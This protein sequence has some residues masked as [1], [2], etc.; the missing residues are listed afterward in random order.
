MQKINTA[1][2]VLLLLAVAYLLTDKFT[3][4]SSKAAQSET[5]V[6]SSTSDS[7]E[8]ETLPGTGQIAF[9]NLD[10]LNA[11][12]TFLSDKLDLMQSEQLRQQ[13]NFERQARKVEERYLALQ[14]EAYKMTQDQLASAQTEMEQ[15]Q[16]QLQASQDRIS[17]ELIA[18]ESS[19][20]SELDERI[21]KELDR[22][23]SK[24]GFDYILAKASGSGVL[25]A[26]EQYDITQE[27][28]DGLNA[29]YEAEQRDE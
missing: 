4:A 13:K 9:V 20:Q 10:T 25:L 19:I 15:A 14:D 3:T 27:V 17:R 16:G 1:L 26:Q 5:T 22:V 24:Y 8:K 29:V 21:N 28:L 7:T 18:L 12:F 6:I 11:Q 2:V 23:N